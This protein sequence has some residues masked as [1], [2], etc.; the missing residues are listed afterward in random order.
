M[1]IVMVGRQL[2]YCQAF[3]LIEKEISK[4]QQEGKLRDVEIHSFMGFGDPISA[5]NTDIC[6]EVSRASVVLTGMSSTPEASQKEVAA[7]AAAIKANVPCGCYVDTH[8]ISG[9]PQFASLRESISFLFVPTAEERDFAKKLF[10]KSEIV[11]SG[12]PMREKWAFP[13]TTREEVRKTL[14]VTGD[15]TMILVPGGG[16]T[17]IVDVPLFEQAVTA[18]Y[19]LTASGVWKTHIIVSLHPG[20]PH[21]PEAYAALSDYAGIPVQ[22]ISREIMSGSEAIPGCDLVVQSGSTIG[23]EAG[24]QRKPVIE[25]LPHITRRRL[26]AIHGIPLEE[27]QWEL[28]RLGISKEVNNPVALPATMATLLNPDSRMSRVQRQCQEKYCFIPKKKGA[29][30]DAMITTLIKYGS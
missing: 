19:K 8:K 30:V 3:Q 26:P 23:E 11:L 16:K 17:I 7:L 21:G 24:Y 25:Y 13:A 15:E 1:K 9:R 4:R 12:N 6:E 10:P 18:G 22:V 14:G 27:Y 20:D 5:S 28:C 29:A 2:A